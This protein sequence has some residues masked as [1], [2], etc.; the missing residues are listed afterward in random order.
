MP[1]LPEVETVRRG[2]E[3][4]VIG[5]RVESVD[6]LSESSLPAPRPRLDSLVVGRRLGRIRRRGKLLV[7]DLDGSSHLL[8]HLMMTG[9]LVVVDGGRTLFAG[10]HPS[11][12]MLEPMPNATTRAVFAFAGGRLLYFNDGRKFGRIRLVDDAALDA[13]P[14]L[15]RLGPE[16]LGECFS[17]AG[18]RAQLE[19]HARAPVKAVLLD[20]TVVAGIGNIYADESLHVARIHPGRPAGSLSAGESRRLRAAI[21]TTLTL[22]VEHG[23]TSFAGY[24]NEARGR[25]S[26]LDRARVF[27]RGGLPCPVCGTTIERTSVAG[28]GT[29][30]CPRCQ[31]YG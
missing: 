29:G 7:L 4:T 6:V 27:R 24:V 25:D 16:P 11:R 2:L 14:F 17:L 21:R 20:Q 10:G 3:A 1:E 9:Q 5:R 8:V 19:R 12:S 31:P 30:F 28:R 15:A 26:Y 13:D 18:F 23:G 22:A